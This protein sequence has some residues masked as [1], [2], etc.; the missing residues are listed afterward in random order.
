M[1]SPSIIFEARRRTNVALVVFAATALFVGVVDPDDFIRPKAETNPLAT[2]EVV[3]EIAM[4]V[5][6]L[7]AYTFHARMAQ[8]QGWI[9]GKLGVQPPFPERQS[10]Q[11]RG[12]TAAG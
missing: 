2:A 9:H 5:A 11:R 4:W 8:A 6:V 7:A 3:A 10:Q 1:Q 12:A